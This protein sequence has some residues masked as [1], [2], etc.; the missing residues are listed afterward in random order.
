MADVTLPHTLTPGTPENVSH[1]QANDEALRDG[2]N[3]ISDAN[4]GTPL[5]PDVLGDGVVVAAGLNE[6]GV[7]RRG[8]SIIAAEESRTNTVYGTLTTPD[9]VSNVVLP[10]DGLLVVAFQ[11]LWKESVEN[12]AN[13][14]IF[15]GSNQ[16]KIGK[17]RSGPS[18]V[19][20]DADFSEQPGSST[21]DRYSPLFTTGRG[22]K[23][24]NAVI[25]S[26]TNVTTGQVVG[27]SDDGTL[28]DGGPCY[29]FAAAGTYTVSVRYRVTSPGTVTAKERKLWV[30]TLGF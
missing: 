18:T 21:V 1:V 20:C 9:Q 16:L 28:T 4:V 19:E 15:L 27:G 30:W 2:V 22:L 25:N 24:Y 11:A 6:T 29:I 23:T 26:S 5:T 13:A 7:V 12:T 14:A 8:K 10:T 17:P 3:A